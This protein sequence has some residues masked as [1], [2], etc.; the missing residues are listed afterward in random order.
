MGG[1]QSRSEAPL[2]DLLSSAWPL[3]LL[4]LALWAVCPPSPPGTRAPWSW[5][6]DAALAIGCGALTAPL[7][8]AWLARF[9]LVGGAHVA[10]DFHDFCGATASVASGRMG[11]FPP[12]RS[13]LAARLGAAMAD[14]LGLIDAMSVAALL[15]CAGIATGLYLWGRA[16]H[17]RLAGLA[18][19][20]A[21]GTMGPLV[22][23][24]HTLSFYPQSTAV[25][26][27]AT[28]AGALALRFR[29]WPLLVLG[30]VGAGA[31]GLIDT[32][33]IFWTLPVLGLTLLG[34]LRAPP[35][36]WLPR[37][38]LVLGLVGFAWASPELGFVE[39]TTS[40]ESQIDLRKRLEDRN[41]AV[42]ARLATPAD[43][44]F[45]WGR[46]SLMELPRTFLNIAVR[47]ADLPSALTDMPETRLNR[48][49]HLEP[50]RGLGLWAT[51]IVGLGLLRGPDRRWRLLGLL[52]TLAPFVVAL[53]GAIAVQQAE[54]RF[55]A[56]ALPGLAVVLGIAFAELCD[57]PWRSAAPASGWA[58]LRPIGAALLVLGFLVGILPSTLSPA[59]AWRSRITSNAYQMSWMADP[60]KARSGA[61]SAPCRWALAADRAKGIPPTG[62]LWG[63]LD[64]EG[65]AGRAWAKGP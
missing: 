33:G 43:S 20:A 1:C 45:R 5:R 36:W 56:N 48:A 41:L 10:S 25:F 24:S 38:A 51:V 28:G 19:A 8:A 54:V 37:I 14:Q 23:L 26:V 60:S 42:P 44:A 13:V 57:G 64:N 11:D 9:Y 58:R 29:S 39:S 31:C 3:L 50:L 7:W 52:G 62:R 65:E 61:D 22:V 21:G 16:L 12:A 35:R 32:R 4:P 47:S 6:I 30:A 63:G 34:A 55:L 27:L 53:R 40:L 46:S 15:S 17:G 18:A 59:S 2:A 49:R